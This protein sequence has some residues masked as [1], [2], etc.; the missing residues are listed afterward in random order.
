[1]SPQQKGIRDKGCLGPIAGCNI[2]A[3]ACASMVRHA[4]LPN[5]EGS[6]LR[7]RGVNAIELL[8]G[9]DEYAPSRATRSNASKGARASCAPFTN[10]ALDWGLQ[11]RKTLHEGAVSG[12][13]RTTLG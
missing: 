6:R 5:E 8:G 3:G 11:P 13:D 12:D 10:G 2:G 4:R 7:A 9:G 1:M